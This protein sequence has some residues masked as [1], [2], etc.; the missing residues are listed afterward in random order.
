MNISRI[1]LAFT[2]LTNRLVFKIFM[3]FWI[4]MTLAGFILLQVETT[5]TSRITERWRSVTGDAFTVYAAAVV[6]DHEDSS[7]DSSREFLTDLQKRTQI[8]AWL[9]NAQGQEVSGFA[10]EQ[11]RQLPPWL[12]E[13]IQQLVNRARTSNRTEF[14]EFEWVTLAARSAT[15]ASG[16]T[17]VLMGTLSASRYNFWGAEPRVQALRLLAILAMAGLVSWVL[18]HHLTQPLEVL[19]S[20]TQRLASG[21][22]SARA[23][24][25]HDR[26]RDEVARLA[27]DFNSMAARIETLLS[28][29]ER[30][31]IAQRRL[32]SDVAHELRSPLARATVAVELARDALCE[33][34]PITCQE[35]N[36][37]VSANPAQDSQDLV[38]LHSVEDS[39]NR[40]ERET[41]R[42]S[43]LIDRLLIL[44]R[45]E[46]G[47]QQA[48]Q[49]PVDLS[50]LV[51]AIAAD[52][53][54][55][56]KSNHRSVQVVACQQCL[57]SGTT[58]LLRSSIENVVR[59]AVRHTPE[60]THVE[61]LLTRENETD[62]DVARWQQ[63]GTI[64]GCYTSPPPSTSLGTSWAVITVRD[65]GPGIPKNELSEVFRPFYRPSGARERH[66]GGAGLGLSITARA[67]ELHG[68]QYR[69]F[70]ASEGCGLIVELRLPL[71]I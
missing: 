44:S 41:G 68:G 24:L 48:E 36:E 52:A 19:R 11:R 35:P 71:L 53:D 62:A 21:D 27:A 12:T 50:A 56:A 7:A 3:A 63:S 8:R 61:V 65:F 43:E 32:L 9:Y 54:F 58:S 13:R 39:L 5:R 4:A 40:I 59:N 38:N 1:P 37:I 66:S 14:E 42:L 26:R 34:A 30:L 31:M 60:N 22:F 10:Q 51:R 49:T 29:Q 16:R 67:I 46:S 45:L 57:T 64:D 18:A 28:E 33:R 70:N 15:A 20:A 23:F 2:R 69:I 47:V 17:Y 25:N 6:K 55:E